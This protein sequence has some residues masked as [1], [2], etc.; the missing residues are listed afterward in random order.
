M[1]G[2]Q[3]FRD[4]GTQWHFMLAQFGETVWDGAV[5]NATPQEVKIFADPALTFVAQWGM[6]TAKLFDLASERWVL[7][8]YGVIH[9]Y[10]ATS[11]W[12]FM[13]VYGC[14]Y[15]SGLFSTCLY[16]FFDR[17]SW[18]LQSSRSTQSNSSR[19]HVSVSNFKLGLMVEGPAPSKKAN[20]STSVNWRLA[21]RIFW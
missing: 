5:K 20:K 13:D 6:A 7:R 9:V 19:S 2:K 15:S 4:H 10:H 8:V 14:W 16:M 21:I 1:F 17:T 18:G 12:L 3:K 11:L